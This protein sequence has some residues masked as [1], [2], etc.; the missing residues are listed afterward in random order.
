M[1]TI[2]PSSERYFEL[3]LDKVK[4]V[5]TTKSQDKACL[6]RSELSPCLLWS[7]R[8]CMTEL[9]ASLNETCF[10]HLC[11]HTPN[12]HGPTS[13]LFFYTAQ[14]G[15]RKCRCNRDRSGCISH[16]RPMEVL[17]RNL[18]CHVDSSFSQAYDGH[19]AL[20]AQ[21]SGNSVAWI[22][23]AKASYFHPVAYFHPVTYV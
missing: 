18:H 15:A 19:T 5:N 10:S 6:C 7:H 1:S 21:S 14:T 9:H 22:P 8:R 12:S 3:G 20:H 16:D 11:R 4:T 17:L 2:V 23:R 13:D